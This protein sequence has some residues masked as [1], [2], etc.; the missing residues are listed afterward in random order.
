M[1]QN[2]GNQCRLL[3][4]GNHPQRAPAMGTGLD[5]D[6]EDALE[7][8]HPGHWGPRLVGV[9]PTLPA[10]RHDPLTVLEVRREHAME[11]REIQ[12][13]PGHQGRAFS[14][15]RFSAFRTSNPLIHETQRCQAAHRGHGR[16]CHPV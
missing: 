3:D 10:P 16:A 8:L 4:T 11:A 7:A 5:V 14:R 15:Q 13:R 12:A 6:G 1:P 9:H 2:P